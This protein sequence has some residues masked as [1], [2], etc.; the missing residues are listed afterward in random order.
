MA[1]FRKLCW[2]KDLGE[3]GLSLRNISMAESFKAMGKDG[4]EALR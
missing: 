4:V 3:V 2:S 1:W